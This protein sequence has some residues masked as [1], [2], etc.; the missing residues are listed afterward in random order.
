[1]AVYYNTNRKYVVKT[2][3]GENMKVSFLLE[4]AL[5]Q[6]IAPQ[7]LETLLPRLRMHKEQFSQKEQSFT[8]PVK[9]YANWELLYLAVSK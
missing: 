4:T 7:E 9:G 8:M 1:M 3:K 2:T 6:G 5:F